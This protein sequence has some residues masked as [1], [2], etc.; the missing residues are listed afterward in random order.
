VVSTPSGCPR[1]TAGCTPTSPTGVRREVIERAERPRLALLSRDEA[2][3]V[4]ACRKSWPGSMRMSSLA[5][6]PVS[7]QTGS[8]AGSTA[9]QAPPE[10]LMATTTGVGHDHGP[11]PS[12]GASFKPRWLRFRWWTTRSMLGFGAIWHECLRRCQQ[13]TG[14]PTYRRRGGSSSSNQ[15]PSRAA[16][17]N[18][19]TCG[20]TARQSIRTPSW[21]RRTSPTAHHSAR[22]APSSCPR[23][24]GRVPPG[25]AG[26][27]VD[28]GQPGRCA[29][30]RSML[31][32]WRLGAAAG[33]LAWGSL[34]C[35][36]GW[37]Q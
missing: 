12:G 9:E 10:E 31:T 2:L 14:C 27:R 30:E 23:L 18:G 25:D 21:P 32:A 22:R 28:G 17:L 3:V 24:A 15:S 7:W 11:R 20:L 16:K 29:A 37:N 26:R 8:T 35:G 33:D 19:F 13:E 36:R 1:T 6:W 4:H 34:V 5:C